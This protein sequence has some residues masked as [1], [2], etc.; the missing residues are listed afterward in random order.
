MAMDAF[1]YL[2]FLLKNKLSFMLFNRLKALEFNFS[3]LLNLV[4]GAGS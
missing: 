1:P 2:D 4:F 3:V